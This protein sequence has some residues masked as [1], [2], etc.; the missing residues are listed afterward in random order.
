MGVHHTPPSSMFRSLGLVALLVCNVSC[1]FMADHRSLLHY[2]QEGREGLYDRNARP[3]R[4]DTYYMN[5]DLEFHLRGIKKVDFEAGVMET[6]GWIGIGGLM[7][8]STG[9]QNSSEISRKLEYHQRCSGLLISTCLMMQAVS[10]MQ[11]FSPTKFS[12]WLPMMVQC[13]GT[14]QQYSGHFATS[15]MPMPSRSAVHWSLVPGCTMKI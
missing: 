15:Q 6:V 14:H 9:N 4:D 3:V 13:T 1:T 8:T 10:T 5:I 2:L 7:S 11:R 12:S